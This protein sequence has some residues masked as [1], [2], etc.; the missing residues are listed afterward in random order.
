VHRP[1]LREVPV[2]AELGIVD[3]SDDYADLRA[4]VAGLKRRLGSLG[5]SYVDMEARA[6]A[7]EG[8]TRKTREALEASE[9]QRRIVE[10]DLAALRKTIDRAA[11][12]ML[13]AVSDAAPRSP[14]AG[15]PGPCGDA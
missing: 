15:D 10:A 4:E 5:Q 8:E 11:V 14:L 3:L 7:A 12:K 6:I 2:M 13:V 9:R 1:R